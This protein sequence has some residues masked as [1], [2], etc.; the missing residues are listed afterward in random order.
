MNL[1]CKSTHLTVLKQD[2]ADTNLNWWKNLSNNTPDT[3]DYRNSVFNI[4][5]V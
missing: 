3:I 4:A 1:V 2:G 5:D